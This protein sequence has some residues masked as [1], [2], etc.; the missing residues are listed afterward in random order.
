MLLHPCTVIPEQYHI[1]HI[2]NVLIFC[3]PST[4]QVYFIG[5]VFNKL[6]VFIPLEFHYSSVIH[7]CVFKTKYACFLWEPPPYFAS[8]S[9]SSTGAHILTSHWQ[10][11]VFAIEEKTSMKSRSSC[12]RSRLNFACL[13]NF[14]VELTSKYFSITIKPVLYESCRIVIFF[15]YHCTKPGF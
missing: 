5:Y 8:V 12:D 10:F 14:C 9:L 11:F 1:N 13:C 2:R 4:F 7:V 6:K 3:H 15:N